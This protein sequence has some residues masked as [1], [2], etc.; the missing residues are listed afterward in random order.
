M[1]ARWKIL[2]GTGGVIGLGVVI[3]IVSHSRVVTGDDTTSSSTTS[4]SDVASRD[5]FAQYATPGAIA[6]EQLSAADRAGIDHIQEVVDTSQPASSYEAFAA[7]TAS[8]SAN[9]ESQ[10]AAR[11][12]GLVDTPDDGVVP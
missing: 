12:V 11:G 6:Y 10:L 3:A 9:V 2:G 7:A 5:P 1:R 4:A 8:T